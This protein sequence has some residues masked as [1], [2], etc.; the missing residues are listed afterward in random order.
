MWVAPSPWLGAWTEDELQ[1]SPCWTQSVSPKKPFLFQLPLVRCLVLVRRQA[2]S[3]VS[4]MAGVCRSQSKCPISKGCFQNIPSRPNPPFTFRILR[5]S[6]V[7][8]KVAQMP[9]HFV[10]IFK[11]QQELLL[12]CCPYLL[13]PICALCPMANSH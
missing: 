10:I 8:L 3:M 7:L 6:A 13:I 5:T 12:F 4:D 9:L 1:P 11:S 2:K